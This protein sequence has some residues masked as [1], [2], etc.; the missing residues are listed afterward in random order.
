MDFVGG[1][2]GYKAYE[3]ASAIGTT[4]TGYYLRKYLNPADNSWVSAGKSSQYDIIIRYAEV[5][6]NKA[7]ALAQ[8]N[9]THSRCLSTP[10]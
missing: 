2:D 10:T 3:N 5:L 8:S 7:E 4:V 6:L 9:W 1:A